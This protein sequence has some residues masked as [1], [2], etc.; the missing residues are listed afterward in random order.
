MGIVNLQC[1]TQI[2]WL[3]WLK[4]GYVHIYIYIY[5]QVTD[6]ESWIEIASDFS[7]FCSVVTNPRDPLAVGLARERPSFQG[8]IQVSQLGWLVF[9]STIVTYHFLKK[10]RLLL[11]LRLHIIHLHFLPFFPDS[12][13]KQRKNTQFNCEMSSSWP[14]STE[15]GWLAIAVGGFMQSTISHS[16]VWDGKFLWALEKGIPPKTNQHKGDPSFED[17]QI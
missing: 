1:Y 10:N 17:F 3:F 8:K 7:A 6:R 9:L 13:G 16:F 15:A 2:P 4:E 5:S 11:L 12:T 14:F